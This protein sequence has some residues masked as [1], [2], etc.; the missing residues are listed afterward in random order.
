VR[1]WLISTIIVFAALTPLLLL[2]GTSLHVLD[3]TPPIYRPGAE[4][5]AL[6]WLAANSDPQETV[7]AAYLSGNVI[8]ARAGNRVVLGLG[9]QTVDAERKRA[10]VDQFYGAAATDEWRR[11]LLK[12]YGVAYLWYGPHERAQGREASAPGFDPSGAP[13]LRAIY[14]RDGY[15]VYEVLRETP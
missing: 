5:A 8:P 4:W 9:P 1:R 3:R 6:D 14:D 2:A 13:Y 15:A 10:E 7:L 12:R 11:A